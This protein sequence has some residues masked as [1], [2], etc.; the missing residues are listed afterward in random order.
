MKAD[1]NQIELKFHNIWSLLESLQQIPQIQFQGHYLIQFQ[2]L[3]LF[4][5]SQLLLIQP[6]IQWTE[7]KQHQFTFI[8]FQVWIQF[9]QHIYYHQLKFISVYKISAT[10]SIHTGGRKYTLALIIQD[11]VRSLARISLSTINFCQGMLIERTAPQRNFLV[12][13]TGSFTMIAFK[14][15][16]TFSA[17]TQPLAPVLPLPS[18]Q[19]TCLN[20]Y[21]YNFSLFISSLS[22]S[23]PCLSLFQKGRRLRVSYS[24]W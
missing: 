12:L 13:A 9:T 8:Q 7:W 23:P 18:P 16:C 3:T 6:L 15:T 17:S 20:L 22:P 2:R 14:L 5:R 11:T 19:L 24:V 1:Q 4:K 10:A 21:L